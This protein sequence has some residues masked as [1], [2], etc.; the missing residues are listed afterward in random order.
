M[1]ARIARRATGSRNYRILQTGLSQGLLAPGPCATGGLREVE[2]T[3]CPP[4]LT[5]AL[6]VLVRPSWRLTA[7][8]LS[9]QHFLR[10]ADC[11]RQ[12]RACLQGHQVR[13]AL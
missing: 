11:D 6:R 12:W 9:C 4:E 3:S 7:K 2:P 13:S 10:R 5:K 8:H 1:S